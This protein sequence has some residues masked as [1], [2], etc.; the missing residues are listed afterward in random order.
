MLMC[1]WVV[2]SWL[3]ISISLEAQLVMGRTLALEDLNMDVKK[4]HLAILEAF[5]LCL[6]SLQSLLKQLQVEP[7]TTIGGRY[8]LI[9]S[10]PR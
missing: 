3:H 9:D 4:G 2:E 10:R 5:A 8:R 7:L 6:P 1:H